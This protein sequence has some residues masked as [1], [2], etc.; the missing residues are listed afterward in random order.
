[1][2]CWNARAREKVHH[3][4][5]PSG[6]PKRAS[7]P[8]F[9]ARNACVVYAGP[10]RKTVVPLLSLMVPD[11]R[12]GFRADV[13]KTQP[14]ANQSSRGTVFSRRWEGQRA[15][16]VGPNGALQVSIQREPDR[17]AKA[18]ENVSF[19]IAV[20]IAMPGV[21]QLYDQARARVGLQVRPSVR[22]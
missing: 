20:S 7:T 10:A 6:V 21:V 22:L 4:S 8:A 16:I 19:G 2:S 12:S 14:D 3:R 13:S 5:S 11:D 17:G 15:P 18:D 9:S 1:M